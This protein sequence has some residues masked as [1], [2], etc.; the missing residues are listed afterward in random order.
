M[1]CSRDARVIVQTVL[2]VGV[3]MIATRAFAADADCKAIGAA[4]ARQMRTPTHAWVTRTSEAEGET[5]SEVIFADGVQ[6]VRQYNAWWRGATL[7]DI[8]AR[9]KT[10]AA[11]VASRCER[12]PDEAIGDV[13][14]H[15]FR[16][17]DRPR[18]DADGP[19]RSVLRIWISIKRGLPLREE[20]EFGSG[21]A[22]H[23]RIVKRFEYD[24]VSAP[25][26]ARVSPI[27]A[28]PGG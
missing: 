25:V 19:A 10:I 23:S 5:T 6:Y 21:D 3:A 9:E 26:G 27:T 22:P 14:A 8:V 17:E 2:I 20:F 13:P 24:K 11:R 12:L 4:L 15:L 7:K 28:K 1:T 18:D 16:R